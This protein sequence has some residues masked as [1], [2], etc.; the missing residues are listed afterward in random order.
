MGPD[1]GRSSGPLPCGLKVLSEG[2]DVLGGVDVRMVAVPAFGVA[3]TELLGG[4]EPC[5]PR[6]SSWQRQ[7]TH[8]K[9]AARLAVPDDTAELLRLRVLMFESMGVAAPQVAG[10]RRASPT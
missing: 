6:P 3:G 8:E 4:P 10:E 2:G 5:A 1:H 9:V 7:Q